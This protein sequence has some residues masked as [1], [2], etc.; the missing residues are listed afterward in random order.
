[1]NSL[2][3]DRIYMRSM[4]TRRQHLATSEMLSD[5]IAYLKSKAGVTEEMLKEIRKQLLE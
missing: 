1:M 3:S 4:A 5:H 2:R